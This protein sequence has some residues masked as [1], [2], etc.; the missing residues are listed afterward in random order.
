MHA[1]MATV[2]VATHRITPADLIAAAPVD[3]G[4]NAAGAAAY[5]AR[6]ACID[7]DAGRRARAEL[8]PRAAGSCGDTAAIG[9]LPLVQTALPLGYARPIQTLPL[10]RAAAC[11][12]PAGAVGA[13]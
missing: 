13:L 3:I 7:T 4:V 10:V 1:R 2:A 6:A 12:R 5:L 11:I 8:L 9:A